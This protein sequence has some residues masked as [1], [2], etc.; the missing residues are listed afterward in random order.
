MQL[1]QQNLMNQPLDGMNEEQDSEANTA[2]HSQRQRPET[3]EDLPDEEDITLTG[4]VQDQQEGFT[5]RGAESDLAASTA[6]LFGLESP[7]KNKQLENLEVKHLGTTVTR[8]NQENKS[9]RAKVNMQS[10]KMLK[11]SLLSSAG[12]YDFESDAQYSY[13]EQ[14]SEICHLPKQRSR[15]TSP[16]MRKNNA[17]QHDEE[18]QTSFIASKGPKDYKAAREMR[19]SNGFKKDHQS[20]QQ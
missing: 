17:K 14:E 6:S 2:R 16:I 4:D 18:E 10:K 15:S 9:Q 8:V 12:V 19:R 7:E 1:I 11:N 5:E 13:L 20:S 3:I